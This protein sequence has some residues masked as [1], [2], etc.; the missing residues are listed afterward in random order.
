MASEV[1]MEAPKV[2]DPKW[3]NFLARHVQVHAA[4][5]STTLKDRDME[6]TREL[7]LDFLDGYLLW[8]SPQRRSLFKQSFYVSTTYVQNVNSG[9][10]ES[11]QDANG[12]QQVKTKAFS[13]T[14]K[15]PRSPEIARR[16][17]EA[18]LVLWRSL[19]TVCET[20][21]H[22]S[23]RVAQLFDWEVQNNGPLCKLARVLA[24]PQI[25]NGS[26]FSNFV[27]AEEIDCDALEIFVTEEDITDFYQDGLKAMEA[28]KLNLDDLHDA[29]NFRIK[30]SRCKATSSNGFLPRLNPNCTSF[31]IFT[32]RALKMVN[33]AHNDEPLTEP[34][35]P[36]VCL[37]LLLSCY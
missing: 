29:A 20:V 26:E 16:N 30:P 9:P 34:A 33:I 10:D 25:L 17:L 11:I 21:S 4:T 28:R 13:A 31:A 5:I 35:S 32:I 14:T 36:H 18:Y 8:L 24:L 19:Y 27:S 2:S 23:N 3:T 22:A 6:E 12:D 7:V 15:R 1:E 37:T